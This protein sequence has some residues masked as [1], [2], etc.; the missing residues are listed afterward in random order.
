MNDYSFLL[1]SPISSLLL[2]GLSKAQPVESPSEMPDFKQLMTMM[3]LSSFS[4][5]S[6]SADGSGLDLNSL[7]APLMMSMLEKLLANQV[8]TAADTASPQG[9]PVEG[10]ITQNSHAGHVALDFGVPEGTAIKSTMSGKVIYSGWNNEGY[11]NLVIVE[12]GAYRTYYAHLSQLPVEVGRQV[13]AGEVI[14]YS[15][16]TGNSTG[17]HLHYEIRLNGQ[18]IDPTSLTL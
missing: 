18:K 8:T 12:N 11:G 4:S 5:T 9:K 10:P 1:D 16:N 3:M 7:M 6:G 13:S 15:G 14:G 2:Q 17:P